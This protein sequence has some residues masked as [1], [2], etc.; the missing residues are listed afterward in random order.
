MS[1][2]EKV[3]YDYTE[4]ISEFEDRWKKQGRAVHVLK[5]PQ[6]TIADINSAFSATELREIADFLDGLDAD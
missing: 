2:F 6:L 5:F 1:T 4:D 3:P